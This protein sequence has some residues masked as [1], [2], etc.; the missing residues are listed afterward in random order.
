M[1]PALAAWR[2]TLQCAGTLSELWLTRA[3]SP[4]G[5]GAVAAARAA[6]LIRHAR[7][8]SPFYR[9]LY[10]GRRGE[11]A[12][13]HHLPVVTKSALMARFDEWATD[14]RI[15]RAAVGAF[16]ADRS[17]SGGRFLGE[18][19]VWKSSGTNGVPGVFVQDENALAVYDAL[20]ARAL[21]SAR[22]ARAY[23]WGLLAAGGRAA[24]VSATTDHYAAA[25]NWR[26]AYA[27]SPWLPSRVISVTAPLTQIVAALNAFEP[28]LLASYPSMLALLGRERRA[29]RLAIAPST[30]WAGGE[31]VSAATRRQIEH[32]FEAPLQ[33][34]YGASEALSIASECP[35]GWLHVNADWVILEPVFAD[36][37]PT[38][39]GTLSDTVLLTN[40]ANRVQPI[41]RY[42]LG[43]RVVVRPEP[44]TCGNPLPAIRVQGRCGDV[45]RLRGASGGV[46]E[47]LPL[48]IETAIEEAGVDAFQVAQVGPHSLRVR[49]PARSDPPAAVATDQD[50]AV[51]AL[52]A[53]V[54]RHGIANADIALDMRP[55]VPLLPSGKRKAI[56]VEC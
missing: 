43:D 7:R 49:L 12:T 6:D 32:D 31:S 19:A 29:G 25:A 13:L 39:A 42:D 26:R 3:A 11:S 24:L 23:A 34:E 54:R 17:R 53:L 1:I 52:T 40:L 20:V 10:H 35:D 22:L 18:F 44:C 21:D 48:A 27:S 45:V 33:N 38:P 56:V 47:L 15:T 46:V 2:H 14:R 50:A 4:A 30:L 51:A 28:C 55:P 8:S 36:G 16:I 9:A 41:I 5:I 37:S